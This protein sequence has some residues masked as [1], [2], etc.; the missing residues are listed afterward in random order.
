[1]FSACQIESF[2]FLAGIM[3]ALPTAGARMQGLKSAHRHMVLHPDY[4]RLCKTYILLQES[5]EVA[6]DYVL[7][8]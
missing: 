7:F 3:S 2:G 5:L 4:S 6:A 8:N 1:M